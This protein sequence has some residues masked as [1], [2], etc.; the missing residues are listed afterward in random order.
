MTAR[1]SH[2]IPTAIPT[3][4][5]SP[6][7]PSPPLLTTCAFS[8]YSPCLVGQTRALRFRRPSPHAQA[9]APARARGAKRSTIKREAPGRA[10]RRWVGT[11]PTPEAPCGGGGPATGT[12]RCCFISPLPKPS[13]PVC[14]RSSAAFPLLTARPLI[15]TL[16]RGPELPSR[17]AP[18][19][20]TS[21]TLEVTSSSLAPAHLCGTAVQGEH[22]R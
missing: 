3:R 16:L 1:P 9:R 4:W 5:C 7:M 2:A 12:G 17:T 13:P 6:T 20:G 19:P 21:R 10:M 8:I 22:G 14:S 11:A 15:P 18:M